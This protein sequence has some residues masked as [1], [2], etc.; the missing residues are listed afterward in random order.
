VFPLQAGAY[1]AD[2]DYTAVLRA[3]VALAGARG[4]RYLFAVIDARELP[5]IR[6]LTAL[7]FALIETRLYYHLAL[8]RYEYPRRFQCRLATA[9]DVDTL[10]SL[11]RTT[12]NPYD[13][14][15]ADPFIGREA[16]VRL[17]DRWIRASVAEGWADATFVPDSPRPNALCTVK[18]HDDRKPAW[19]LSIAQLVLAMG[20]TA[21][22]RFLGVIAETTYHLKARGADHVFFTTQ[23]PNHPLIRVAEHLGFTLGRGEHVF[24]ILL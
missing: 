12:A 23:L 19:G 2:A 24:R 11:A 8:R 10:A 22:S 21:G 1:D 5:T 20:E 14:F 3:L 9:A 13:R 7:G 17:V 4:V 16:A 6:A 18:Y 15:N